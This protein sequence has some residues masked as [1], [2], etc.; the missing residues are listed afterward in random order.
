MNRSTAP[1]AFVPP[2]RIQATKTYT[3]FGASYVIRNTLDP[4]RHDASAWRL[5]A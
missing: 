3:V 4:A 2:S 1:G 5:A